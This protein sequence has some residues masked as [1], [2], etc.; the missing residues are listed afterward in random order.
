MFFDDTI[1]I[2]QHISRHAFCSASFI[3]FD[4]LLAFVLEYYVLGSILLLLYFSTM[5]HWNCVRRMSVIK[6]IDIV[7]AMSD[8]FHVT[9]IDSY[10]FTPYYR[11][12]WWISTTSSF[13]MFVVNEILFYYQVSTEKNPNRIMIKSSY[14]HYFSLE[15]TPPNSQARE[16]AYYRNVFTHMFFLHI[17]PP[18]VSV[19]C[20][21]RSIIENYHNNLS[22]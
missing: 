22:A 2:P 13:I 6:I 17:L 19:I 4:S 8:M 7:L 10:R 1:I 14:F 18:C 3:L 11:S 12:V 20:A 21:S 15:Y 16:L 9:L 5:L